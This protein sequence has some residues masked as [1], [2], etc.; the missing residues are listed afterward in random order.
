MTIYC[1]WSTSIKSRTRT[2]LHTHHTITWFETQRTNSQW[3]TAA[4]AW[5]SSPRCVFVDSLICVQPDQDKFGMFCGAQACPWSQA[6]RTK[7]TWV[8][9]KKHKYVTY[10]PA[11]NNHRPGTTKSACDCWI[12]FVPSNPSMEIGIIDVSIWPG[13]EVLSMRLAVLTVSPKSLYRGLSRPTTPVAWNCWN[14]LKR[15]SV[16]TK[17]LEQFLILWHG[18]LLAFGGWSGWKASQGWSH[19]NQVLKMWLVEKRHVQYFECTSCFI[20]DSCSVFREGIFKKRCFSSTLAT[21]LLFVHTN[22]ISGDEFLLSKCVLMTSF[23]FDCDLNLPFTIRNICTIT[24]QICTCPYAATV[25]SNANLQFLS[26]PQGHIWFSSLQL[27]HHTVCF[28]TPHCNQWVMGYQQQ[29]PLNVM[30]PCTFI[31]IQF[32]TLSS[33]SSSSSIKFMYI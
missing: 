25:Q 5:N 1:L 3:Q 32:A 7:P 29:T 24:L 23:E 33:S 21:P 17:W 30:P 22:V 15:R 19:L 20:S 6:N 14:M 27:L 18:G 4:S 2:G 13:S 28:P 12:K 31:Q 10:S 16:E 9:G 8:P 26:L 11:Q